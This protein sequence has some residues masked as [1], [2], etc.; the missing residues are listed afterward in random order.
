VLSRNDAEA[1]WHIDVFWFM[2]V[3]GKD[4]DG[5]WS[6]MDQHCRREPDF[7]PAPAHA[8]D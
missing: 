1:R 2:L 3:H 8:L 6:T 7:K 4:T 5:R